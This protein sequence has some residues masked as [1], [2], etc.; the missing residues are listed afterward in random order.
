MSKHIRVDGK[1]LQ[2]NKR[3]SN[4]KQKQQAKIAGWMYEGYESRWREDEFN[5]VSFR[6][7][8]KT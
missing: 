3:Y 6:R 5:K 2:V 4:L 1:L 8:N 7:Y